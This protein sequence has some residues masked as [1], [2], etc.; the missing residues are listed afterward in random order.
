MPD[1][2]E[3]KLLLGDQLAP[4]WHWGVNF[5]WEAEVGG[6]REQEF[7]VTGG[8]SYSL[9]DSKLGVGIEMFYDHD[10]VKGARGDEANIFAIGP[11]IQ[12]RVT[13]NVHVDFNVLFGTN[14][15]SERQIGFLVVGYDFGPGES[16]KHG[17][18][19]ISGQ[20]N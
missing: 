18:T 12:W 17:Y 9:I 20:R 13:K 1:V 19:P 3:L 11:S 16:K 10:T 14:R 5:V 6:D 2:Y 7:Q 8:L 4:R 15:D